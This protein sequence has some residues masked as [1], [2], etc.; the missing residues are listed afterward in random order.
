MRCTP[1]ALLAAILLSVS[2]ASAQ[3][4]DTKEPITDDG[5]QETIDTLTA[6]V[7]GEGA[8]L[9]AYRE[10]IRALRET[11][12]YKEAEQRAREYEAQRPGSNDLTNTLG[13]ILYETG[14]IDAAR[15]AF[16]RANVSRASDRR[17]AQL[18]LAVLFYERG[19]ID[20]AM[21]RFDAFIDVYNLSDKLS[22][23]ELTAVGSACRYLGVK[24]AQLFKDALKAF[25]E[26]IREDPGNFEARLAVGELFLD[27]YNS[28]DARESFAE[29]L[30]LNPA[31]PR[32]MLGMARVMHFDGSYEAYELTK[33]ALEINPNLVPA[34][35]F[36]GRLELELE[37]YEEAEREAEQA[38]DIN[39][40]SLEALT[41]LATARFL[42]GDTAGFED[43]QKRAF[44]LNPRY[45]DFYNTIADACVRNRL[46]QEASDFARQSVGLDEKSW[47]GY[48]ILGLNQ[49]RLGKIEK[50]RQNLERSFSG[51]PYNVWIK[52]TLDLIDTFPQYRESRSDRF[53]IFIDGKESD[54]LSIYATSLLEEAYDYLAQRYQYHPPT[55]IR[56]EAYPSHADFSVRTIG[57]AGLGALGVC[58][59][60]VVAIDSPSARE[61]GE[62]NWGSTLWHELAHT[63]TLG[64]TNNKIPRWFSEGLS[65]YEERLARP[66][67]GDDVS[68]PFLMAYQQDKLLSLKDLNNGFVRPTYPQQITNSYYQ[69]SLI[70]ELIERD[71]GF[72]A[73]LE[74][75]AGYKAG[76]STE[77]IFSSVLG[78]DPDCFDEK[79]DGYLEKRF[80]HAADVLPEPKEDAPAKALTLQD[81]TDK[82]D[83]EPEN[84]LAQ[85]AMGSMLFRENKF[86]EAEPYLERAKTLFPEYGGKDS[87]YWYLAQIYK[88]RGENEKASEMLSSLVSINSNHYDAHLELAELKRQLN[89]EEGSAEI[90]E[91]AVY[92][93]PFEVSI[94]RQMAELYQGLED[95]DKVIRE[96][97]VL[98]AIEV[99]DRAQVLYELALAYH[100]AGDTT[101]AR[102]E[103]LKALEIAPSFD[104]ALDLLLKLQPEESEESS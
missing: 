52:N 73:I 94:H 54:I 96:R 77:T 18:N 24:D 89:D 6:I 65:V 29:I 92:I 9:Q 90:L 31:H 80:R 28:P 97:K 66:G 86:S 93:Y 99:A 104:D 70:C 48:G 71:H 103:V 40:V 8:N 62:F 38:L 16:A 74:M 42:K 56:V 10:L 13:E 26:A 102:R 85:L 46:Y 88:N 22:S 57:L 76:K 98:V 1:V 12:R 14:R 61:K 30:S 7:E 44:S 49:L 84:F 69:A 34:H 17:I 19:E 95:Y 32:A 64:V 36:L 87:P 35:V 63:V 68:I 75:L 15:D 60:P 91:R 67:W 58:F 2:S 55:P 81:L 79:F 51:D 37:N 27:K 41:L 11:G 25:D 72:Q 39:P 82:A 3:P 47:S 101:G 83:E 100:Q 45:A 53:L 4:Q 43:A 50:G 59:G 78:C 20:E 23:E 5:Y 21:L 33:L